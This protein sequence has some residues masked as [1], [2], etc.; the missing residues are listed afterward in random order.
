MWSVRQVA[1]AAFRFAAAVEAPQLSG[2]TRSRSALD[3]RQLARAG[4]L[5]AR[6][7]SELLDSFWRGPE[8]AIGYT[9]LDNKV[10][11]FHFFE[12]V[13]SHLELDRTA[14]APAGAIRDAQR[15]LGHEQAVWATE[16]IGYELFVREHQAGRNPSGLLSGPAEGV[17]DGSWTVLHTGMG[18]AL[19][20]ARLQGI[21]NGA[22]SGQLVERLTE[23]IGACEEVSRTGFAE[24]AFEPL[25][26]VA[27][28]LRPALV[29]PIAEQLEGIGEPWSDL[30]WHGLGRGLYFLPANLNPRRSAPWAG[31]A[32]ARREPPHEAGRRGAAAGFAWAVTL[33]N[34]RRPEVVESFLVHHGDL[35]DRGDPVAQ[36]VLSALLLWYETTRGSR[37]LRRFVAHVAAPERRHLWQRVLREP[38]ENA[39]R[40]WTSPGPLGDP[41]AACELFR[42]RCTGGVTPAPAVA[43]RGGRPRRLR[44]PSR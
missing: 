21:S 1:R 28:L 8:V 33:V 37:E 27:G 13:V 17:P 2:S 9:E 32:R 20:E 14:L 44:H 25:G 4:L 38:Y 30:F 29:G 40:D 34:L 11:A 22:G 26:L 31:L 41:R 39:V 5:T 12:S 6:F 15:R 18:M 36:G 7:G 16:G 43:A 10:R 23:Y 3:P 42:Y 19:A 35:A 24:L